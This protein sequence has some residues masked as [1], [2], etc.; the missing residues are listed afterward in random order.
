M[1]FSPSGRWLYLQFEHKNLYR[2][3]GPAQDWKAAEPQ[4]VTDFP[5]S[6]GLFLE[7]P[8]FSLDGK[9]LLFSRGRISGDIWILRR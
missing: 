8:Q 7:D 6:A 9:Q 3:P 5:E 2:V 4:K 1:L